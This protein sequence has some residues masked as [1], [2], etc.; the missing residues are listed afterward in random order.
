M[1][2]PGV[3]TGLVLTRALMCCTYWWNS[4]QRDALLRWLFKSVLNISYMATMGLIAFSLLYPPLCSGDRV[5]WRFR[6]RPAYPAP[7]DPQGRGH[8]WVY[9]HQQCGRDQH[10]RQTH[11]PGRYD[12]PLAL[13]FSVSLSI[14]LFLDF[15]PSLSLALTHMHRHKHTHSFPLSLCLS[16]SSLLFSSSIPATMGFS[17]LISVAQYVHTDSNHVGMSAPLIRLERAFYVLLLLVACLVDEI[18][19]IHQFVICQ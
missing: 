14:N 15:F 8:L 12:T 7:A 5:W 16:L 1:I 19:T 17:V 9:C 2:K 13:L 11:R 10:Q 3:F 18:E 6:V 4:D